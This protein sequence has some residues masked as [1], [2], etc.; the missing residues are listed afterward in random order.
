MGNIVTFMWTLAVFSDLAR[1]YKNDCN[2]NYYFVKAGLI[3]KNFM[4]LDDG[5]FPA[6]LCLCP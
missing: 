2:C 3:F 6:C 5:Y 1:K 4:Y